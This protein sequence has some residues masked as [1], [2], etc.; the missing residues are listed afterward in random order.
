MMA[1]GCQDQYLKQH[2]QTDSSL[3]C[4]WMKGTFV[5]IARI[6]IWLKFKCPHLYLIACCLLASSTVEI[7]KS[8]WPT[9]LN[10]QFWLLRNPAVSGFHTDSA[11]PKMWVADVL[12][13]FFTGASCWYASKENTQLFIAW[14]WQM[15]PCCPHLKTWLS[16]P[17][18]G[19]FA[20]CWWYLRQCCS[21]PCWVGAG[22]ESGL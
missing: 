21:T 22:R 2:R 5:C 16:I 15:I 10:F 7:K 8:V 3:A 4:A 17:L 19:L 1:F 9:E 18:H 12:D 13:H 11:P 20:R 6:Q 14:V